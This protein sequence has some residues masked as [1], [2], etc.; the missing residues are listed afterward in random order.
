MLKSRTGNDQSVQTVTC[1]ICGKR[2]VFVED[3]KVMTHV[4][5]IQDGHNYVTAT[6]R[7][8]TTTNPKTIEVL[9]GGGRL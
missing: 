3:D 2:L 5:R 6:V 8:D 9:Q 1:A 7:L 4:L